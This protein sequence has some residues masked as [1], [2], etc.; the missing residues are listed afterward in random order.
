VS[1]EC[2]IETCDEVDKGPGKMLLC[3][4]RKWKESWKQLIQDINEEIEK[5]KNE[6]IDDEI[7]KITDEMNE[8]NKP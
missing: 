2:L 4:F 1:L 3:N 7:I 6:V 8:M 5:I